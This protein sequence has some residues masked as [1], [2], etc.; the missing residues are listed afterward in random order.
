MGDEKKGSKKRGRG[1]GLWRGLVLG[2]ALAAAGGLEREPPLEP[3]GWP[4][5]RACRLGWPWR[6]VGN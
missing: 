3:T 5:A 2:T 1:G 6:A 4:G